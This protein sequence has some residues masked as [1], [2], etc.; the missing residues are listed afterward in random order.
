MNKAMVT[1]GII[2]M[3]I[4][5]VVAIYIST[6]RTRTRLL[7]IKRYNRSSYAR[8]NDDTRFLWRNWFK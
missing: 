6:N 3:F 7:S 4:L 8:F 1:I 5:G 2:L